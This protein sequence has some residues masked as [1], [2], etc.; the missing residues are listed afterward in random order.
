MIGTEVLLP[1]VNRMIPIIADELV[2]QNSEL[3]P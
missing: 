3:A 2:V 1:L